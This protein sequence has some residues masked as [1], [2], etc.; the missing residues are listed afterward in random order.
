LY[1]PAFVWLTISG[2][3]KYVELGTQDYSTVWFALCCLQW[4]WSWK[5]KRSGRAR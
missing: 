2:R 1:L 5:Q 4:S 3:N